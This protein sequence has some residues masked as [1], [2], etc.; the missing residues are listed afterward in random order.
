MHALPALEGL[1]KIPQVLS[2]QKMFPPIRHSFSTC[3]NSSRHTGGE[4]MLKEIADLGF[5]RVELGHGTRVSLLDGIKK[6]VRDL[7]LEI[8]SLHNFCPLPVEVQGSAPD[9]YE[10]TSHRAADRERAL[11][12]TYRTI[13]FAVESGVPFVVLHLGSV[14]LRKDYSRLLKI[15]EEGGLH[16]RDF[17]KAKIAAVKGREKAAPLYF[18]R[19]LEVLGHLVEYA[20]A[21]NTHLCVESRQYYEQ[22]PEENE[23]LR[24]LDELDSPWIGYWHDFGHVQ[25]RENLALLDHAEWLQ[26]IRHR[27]FGCH[28]HDVKWPARDHMPP[29][30]GSIQFENLIPLLPPNCLCVWEMSPRRKAEEII[31]AKAAWEERFPA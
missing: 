7:G 14:P 16:S 15:V 20:A 29:L 21:R 8:S 26:R 30:S 27:L 24:I 9:C 5:R 4:S 13:D 17:V 28:F 2:T 1:P 31:S 6:G 11:K 23:M 12:L 10:F 18:Q 25:I 19:S 3:W 22:I